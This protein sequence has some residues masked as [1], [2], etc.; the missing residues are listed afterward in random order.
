MKIMAVNVS[1]PIEFE[2]KGRTMRSSIF[3]K[4]VNGPVALGKTNLAGDGQANL[5]VHGGAHKAVYAYS[6]DH[7]AWWSETLGR[8]DLSFGQFGENLTISGL[9]EDEIAIGDR[10]L[11][12]TAMTAVTGP[13]IPCA[14]L[15]IKFKDKMM[16]RKFTEA[17]RPGFYL[18]VIETGVVEAGD[19]VEKIQAGEGGLSVRE[20]F[21]AYSRP[22]SR[23]AGEIL[24]HALTLADLDPDFIPRINK[25]LRAFKE[26]TV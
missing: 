1:Q 22:S 8:N 24:E 21:N 4:P 13:R 14:M 9:D 25:R 12:G 19:R 10:L 26:K 11:V 7:Y 2:F 17:A 3:K 6:H 5:K 23:E 18:R 20:I 16:L 15:G